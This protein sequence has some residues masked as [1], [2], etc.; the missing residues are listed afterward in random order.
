MI[1]LMKKIEEKRSININNMSSYYI[2]FLSDVKKI[3]KI[4]RYR[5]S[6]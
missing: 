1:H 5:Q 2:I 4:R 6:V 3:S